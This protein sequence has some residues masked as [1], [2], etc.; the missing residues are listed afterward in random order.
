MSLNVLNLSISDDADAAIAS[1]VSSIDVEGQK[2]TFNLRDGGSK[3]IEV[4]AVPGPYFTPEIGTVETLPAG[5][6]A[7]A[8][9]DTDPDT[10]K[11]TLNLGIPK[12]RDGSGGGGGGGHELT[13]EH[14]TGDTYNGKDVYEIL[15]E[16]HH[17][18][19][20]SSWN[21]AFDLSSLNIDKILS[22]NGTTLSTTS[23]KDEIWVDCNHALTTGDMSGQY[24]KKSTGKLLEYH[25]NSNINGR[26][27]LLT[28]RYTKKEE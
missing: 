4:P 14:L 26:P 21:E 1:G 20:A 18:N 19:S 10:M 28:L 2:V 16:G 13:E 22:L 17:G 25:T 9:I 24:L 27:L 12:G 6:Q 11:A 7:T 15:V 8:S 23:S 5:S 3:S